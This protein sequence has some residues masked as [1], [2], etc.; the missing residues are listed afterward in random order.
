M[1]T[2]DRETKR[3]EALGRFLRAKRQRIRPD[4]RG[5]AVRRRR[6]AQG[7]LREE[8]AEIAG[9]SLT[10]YTWLEQARPTNPSLRVLE[11]L[12]SALGLTPVERAHL[13]RLA[14]PDLDPAEA[15]ASSAL[16]PSLIA[17][18]HGL[19]PHPVYASNARWDVLA[20][21]LPATRVFGDFGALPPH[22]RNIVHRL[23]L[24]PAW[25]SLFVDW[26][27]LAEA[28]VGQFRATTVH[29]ADPAL[30]ALIARLTAQSPLFARTWERLSVAE[31]RACQKTLRH[32]TAGTLAFDYSTFRPE[33][34]A[35]DV[36]FTIY[37]PS[38]AITAKRMHSL[39]A[40]RRGRR[41]AHRT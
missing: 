8:V 10:W 1:P 27:V 15:G 20:W 29:L 23:L 4:E 31:P 30:D 39:L 18:L 22:E 11:G 36:R 24:D 14:R 32:P 34:A 17:T 33:D 6:R 40:P 21:N 5:V 12:A 26:E 37:T 3:R 41:P 38:D 19:A 7:L 9:V 28:T 25:R 2:I 35:T 16:S 13:F